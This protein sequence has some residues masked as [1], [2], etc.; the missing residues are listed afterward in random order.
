MRTVES[1]NQRL[2]QVLHQPMSPMAEDLLADARVPPNLLP[3]T[4]YRHLPTV[5]G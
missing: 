3:L 1:F 5:A 2:I 4:D